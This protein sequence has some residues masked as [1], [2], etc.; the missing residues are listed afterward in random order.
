MAELVP[1]AE[2]FA[3]TLAA[4][5]NGTVSRDIRFVVTPFEGREPAR[6][7]PEGSIPTASTLIP[8]TAGLGADAMPSI[9]IKAAFQVRLDSS[10]DHLAVE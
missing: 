1:A 7:F 6:V 8:V 3:A 9:W 4:V 10:G 5:I 2:E